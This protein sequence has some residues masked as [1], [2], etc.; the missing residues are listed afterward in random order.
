MWLPPAP[1]LD[2]V[3]LSAPETTLDLVTV[4]PLLGFTWI[5]GLRSPSG[6]H[7]ALLTMVLN[8]AILGPGDCFPKLDLKWTR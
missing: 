3:I 1:H 6:P 8:W 5:W 2:L 7:L 4:A